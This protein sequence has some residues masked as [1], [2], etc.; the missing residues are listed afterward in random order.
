MKQSALLATPRHPLVSLLRHRWL[1]AS[2]II[3]AALGA[4]APV[5]GATGGGV[6]GTVKVLEDGKATSDNSGVVVYLENVPGGEVDAS[7]IVKAINQRDKQFRPGKLVVQ[8]GSTVTF[9]ND[10]KIF[11]NVFSLSKAA[12]FDLGLYKSGTSK[13]VKM[14][15]T[16]VV[17]VYC[18]IHPDMVAKILV[19]DTKYYAETNNAGQFSISGVPD[20]TYNLVGWQMFGD[21]Y[22]GQVTISDGK[23][24]DHSFSLEE[25]SGSNQHKR[26]DGTP[27]GRYK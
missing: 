14:R 1:A 12:R 17:D 7:K 24:T 10:D 5:A 15:R 20:G 21:S 26:K 19:I 25:G 9:P 22:K 2:S 16:G 27:Y 4:P 18:N 23:V 6:S 13:S 8:K 11:H 3:S